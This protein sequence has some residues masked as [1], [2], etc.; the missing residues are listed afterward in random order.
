M[1]RVTEPLRQEHS[2][3][4]PHIE[5]LRQAADGVS[6]ANNA[7]LRKQV[8]DAYA[9]LTEYLIPHAQAEDQALYPVV[10]RAMGAEKATTSRDHVEV[11]ILTEELGQLRQTLGSETTDETARNQL[12]RVLYGLY[13]LVKVHFSKEEE[14]YLPILDEQLDEARALEMFQAMEAAAGAAKA[15]HRH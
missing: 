13:A 2:E 6:K 12:R 1:P 9:F 11:G 4:L 5:E 15:A 10:A 3:L 7:T 8:D 14:I